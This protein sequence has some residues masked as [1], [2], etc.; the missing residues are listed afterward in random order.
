[1][2]VFWLMPTETVTNPDRSS[3]GCTL[4]LSL[5]S[6]GESWPGFKR[7]LRLQPP[8][9]TVFSSWLI[10]A[11]N[12][13]V[14]NKINKHSCGKHPNWL[15]VTVS[16]QAPGGWGGNFHTLSGICDVLHMFRGKMWIKI[17]PDSPLRSRCCAGIWSQSQKSLLWKLP[18]SVLFCC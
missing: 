13:V 5:R 16:A 11:L 10:E 9:S 12:L 17:S 18:N 14:R 3:W 7:I 8:S 15:I 4:F 1:M 6:G 2:E